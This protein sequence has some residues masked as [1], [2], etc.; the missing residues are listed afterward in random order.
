MLNLY[1]R[2]KILCDEQNIKI[3]TMCQA[4]GVR[5]GIIS[6]LKAGRSKSLSAATL[7]KIADYFDVSV[8][9]LLGN[10]DIKKEPVTPPGD[11]LSQEI[12]AK[13]SILTPENRAIALAQLDFLLDRQEKQET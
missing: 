6:D 1:D 9:Y 10:T 4:T 11:K 3:F 7:T 13:L 5:S 12:M 8:D 2:I